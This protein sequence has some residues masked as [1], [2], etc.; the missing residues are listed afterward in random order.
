MKKC[1]FCKIIHRGRG[2]FCSQRCSG[3]FMMKNDNYKKQFLISG[4][5]TRY[6]KGQE[7]HKK[8]PK[9]VKI[10][11][12]CKKEYKI[13]PYRNNISKYCSRKCLASA[14]YNTKRPTVKGKKFSKETKEKMSNRMKGNMV[15]FK[16]GQIPWNKGLNKNS[17]EK[18]IEW[19]RKIH[20]DETKRKRLIGLIK[21]PNKPEKK[22]NE[23][24]Q[25]NF[26]HEWKFVGDGKVIIEG[27]N[28][29]FI[30]INGKKQIIEMYGAYWHKPEQVEPRMEIFA[31]YGYKTLIL[32][33]Y[34]LKNEE[35]LMEK[36]N[37]ISLTAEERP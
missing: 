26:P 3:K 17:N 13:H 14:T 11:E 6:Q 37:M 1:L 16:I 35:K 12:W 28:P 20:T 33:D 24:L 2:K 5:K 21:S 23:L 22:L 25:K 18:M 10:C 4:E 29:D 8:K 19:Q 9:I 34:E 31:K 15:G 7:S 30:N 36:I 32:W 27:K